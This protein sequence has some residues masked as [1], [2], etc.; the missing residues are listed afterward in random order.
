MLG[1]SET[2]RGDACVSASMVVY[3]CAFAEWEIAALEGP[4]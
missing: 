2:K 4:T 3:Y 1:T